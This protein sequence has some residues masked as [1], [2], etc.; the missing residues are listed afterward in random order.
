MNQRQSRTEQINNSGWSRVGLIVLLAAALSA[1]SSVPDWANPG[2][3]YGQVSG[4]FKGDGDGESFPTVSDVR[5]GQPRPTLSNV[6]RRPRVWWRT[7]RT[8]SIRMK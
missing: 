6:R 7:A 4:V 5:I 8:L 1:C 3:I 2:K